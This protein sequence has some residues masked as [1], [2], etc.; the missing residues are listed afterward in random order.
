[1]PEFRILGPLE[2]SDDDGPIPLGGRN[3]RALLT[4]LLLHANEPVSIERLV[5]ALWGERA[6]RTGRAAHPLLGL[7]AGARREPARRLPLRA[8]RA[9]RPR[10]RAGRARGAAAGGARALARPRARGLCPRGV[11]PGRDPPPRGRTAGRAR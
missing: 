5:D 2:V 7:R 9:R 8:A 1:M 3:Q 4:L 6:P 11:R 10:S